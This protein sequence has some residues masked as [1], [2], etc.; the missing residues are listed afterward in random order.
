MGNEVAEQRERKTWVGFERSW[1]VGCMGRAN[2][3]SDGE[4]TEMGEIDGAWL[5][6]ILFIKS[7]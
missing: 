6:I 3:K 5:D 7:W 1:F 2:K 4:V